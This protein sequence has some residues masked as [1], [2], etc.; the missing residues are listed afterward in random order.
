MFALAPAQAIVAQFLATFKEYP[1]R[2]N[3]GS[4]SI[5]Q[6]LETRQTGG[7][8]TTF[9]VSSSCSMQTVSSDCH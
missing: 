3:P 4:F 2:Q 7:T 5:D 8:G 6:V 9:S 1:P